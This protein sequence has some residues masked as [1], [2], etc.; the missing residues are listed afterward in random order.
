[1][2]RYQGDV[3]IRHGRIA[4]LGRVEGTAKRVIDASGRIVATWR[5]RLTHALRRANQ[6]GP[7]C[8]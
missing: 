1:M 7:V 4:A 6:L 8:H 3:G 2:P 5:R